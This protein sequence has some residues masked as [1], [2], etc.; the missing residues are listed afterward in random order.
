MWHGKKHRANVSHDTI[1]SCRYYIQHDTH[2]AIA[3][4]TVKTYRVDASYNFKKERII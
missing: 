3:C 1:A 4:V 2:V